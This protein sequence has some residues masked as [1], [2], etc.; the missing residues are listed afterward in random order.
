MERSEKRCPC[1]TGDV[2]GECCE[3]LHRGE[4]EAATAE[5]LMRS[6]F[7]AFAFA[8]ADYVMRTWHPRTRP[9]SVEF[10]PGERW[11]RLEIV[12]KTDGSPFH[13]QG[14]VTF[15]AYFRNSDGRGYLEER[16]SF[17]KEEGRWLY[18]DG[19]AEFHPQ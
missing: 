17:V 9:D 18:R 13:D 6:R 7:S 4:R 11:T 16:S 2:Y 1:G 8:D 5:G 3:P 12:D 14:T 10:D 19:D 15:R